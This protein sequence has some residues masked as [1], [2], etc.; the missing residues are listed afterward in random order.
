MGKKPTVSVCYVSVVDGPIYGPFMG[1]NVTGFPPSA[2]PPQSRDVS[3]FSLKSFHFRE[4]Q[5]Q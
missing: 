3:C 4:L 1:C 2:H 5:E